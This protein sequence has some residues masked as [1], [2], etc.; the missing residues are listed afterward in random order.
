[1][2]MDTGLAT[3]APGGEKT[4]DQRALA[5]SQAMDLHV[6]HDRTHSCDPALGLHRF[7]TG[8]SPASLRR[9]GPIVMT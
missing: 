2:P 9:P 6:K 4:V 8:P 7:P 1:L 5:A 3:T